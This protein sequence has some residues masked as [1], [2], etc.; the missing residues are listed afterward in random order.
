MPLRED[1]LV[2]KIVTKFGGSSLANAAQFSKVRDILQLVPD[3]MYVVPSAPGKRFKEDEKVTDLLYR[4]YREAQAGEDI[5]ATFD[6]ISERYHDIHRDLRLKVD[7]DAHLSEIREQIAAGASADY[8]ASRGEYLNGLLLADYLGWRFL[9][10]AKGVAFTMDGQLDSEKTQAQLSALLDDDVPT[11]V[12][13]FYG[14]APDGTIR[15]FSRGGS[16][17]TGALVARAVQADTYENWTDVSGFLMA[18][19]R[20]VDN[21]HEISSITYKE[22]RELSYMGASVLHEDAMFPVHKAGIPTNIRNTNKPYHPG[23]FILVDAPQTSGTI[24]GIAGKKGFSVISIEKGMMNAE[25]GFGRRV[26]AVLEEAG[27]SFEHLPTGID[28]MCVV[29]D[30]KELAP[31]RQ[32]VLDRIVE[33]T[34]ADSL[35]VHDNMAVIATVGRGMVRNCGTAGRLFLAMAKARVNVRMIDQ[36]SSELSII[37]GVD[38]ADFEKTIRAIY[39]EFVG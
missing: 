30:G 34:N 24:T 19:P 1:K 35:T 18:D 13:G 20:V 2:N 15:T 26:L 16:D 3:R 32:Q 6:K 22:L 14:A 38:D 4:C 36:G 27:L 25:L 8:C 37:V 23:T 29:V 9:D 7:L 21:P 31:V 28:T 11:V 10:S 39:Q 33:V 12:P 17:V 5:T